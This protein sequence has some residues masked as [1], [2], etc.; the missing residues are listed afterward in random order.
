M[1]PS[2][3]LKNKIKQG[4]PTVEKWEGAQSEPSVTRRVEKWLLN[5]PFCSYWLTQDR[6]PETYVIIY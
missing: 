4:K 6:V 1:S 5:G 3:R 2:S